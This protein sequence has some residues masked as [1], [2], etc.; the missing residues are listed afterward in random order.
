MKIIHEKGYDME[1]LLSNT[2][3]ELIKFSGFCMARKGL[4]GFDTNTW[5]QVAPK[6]HEPMALIDRASE[7]YI[8]LPKGVLDVPANIPQRN[9]EPFMSEGRGLVE[10]HFGDSGII[11]ID[12][13]L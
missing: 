3:V 1:I 11:R 2:D 5:I 4:V 9:I 12:R 7:L 8:N 10:W 6:Y 13:E